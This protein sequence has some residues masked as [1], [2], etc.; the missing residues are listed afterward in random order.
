MRRRGFLG[1]LLAAAALAALPAVGLAAEEQSLLAADGTLHVVRAGRAADLGVAEADPDDY[2]ID[3]TSRSQDG[4]VA[5]ALIPGTA[6]AGIKRN[7][8][9]AFDEQTQSFLVLWTQGTFPSSEVRVGVLHDGAWLNSGL[10]PNH[11]L[12]GA[13]NPRMIL[14]HQSVTH[15]DEQDNPVTTMSSILSVIWWEDAQYG[16]ARY[17]TLFL[18]ENGFDPASL[19]IYD[20]P[21]LL[22]SVGETPYDD[23]PS[24]SYLFPSLEADGLS[25]GVIASFADL[26]AQRHRVV[27]IS[28]PEDQ[29]KPSETGNLKWQR[30]HIPIMGVAK[31]GPIARKAPK[32]AAQAPP[33]LAVGTS[34]GAGYKPTLYWLDGDALKFSRLGDSDWE[35]VRAI[36]IDDSMTYDRALSL[37]VGMGKRN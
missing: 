36:T 20:L 14:T 2:V 9:L 18:D 37:V 6:S 26:H 3:W 34:I 16:Q 10:L 29:G 11:G 13:Y 31:D 15:L 8:Q 32:V 5:T 30:R 1:F 12:S 22:G 4:S 19:A 7:L 23:V 21:A 33:E 24:G 35:P 25:G 28:F 17:A 27:R